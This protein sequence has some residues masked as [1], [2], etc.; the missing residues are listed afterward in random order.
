MKLNGGGFETE[1]KMTIKTVIG[2]WRVVE[3][4]ISLAERPRGS[5]SKIRVLRDGMAILGAVLIGRR[6]Y[7]VA[8][9]TG[10]SFLTGFRARD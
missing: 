3:V 7:F 9:F 1:V 4:P 2:G 10:T 5:H 8:F 6:L